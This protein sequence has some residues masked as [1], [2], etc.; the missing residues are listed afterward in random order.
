MKNCAPF[1]IRSPML[2]AA[3]TRL[4]SVFRGP[5]L[6]SIE[7]TSS[8][9]V[10]LGESL[11]AMV[12]TPPF[13]RRDQ[14]PTQGG[15]PQRSV[16]I[17]YGSFRGPLLSQDSGAATSSQSERDIPGKVVQQESTDTIGRKKASPQFTFSSAFAIWTSNYIG[18]WVFQRL[19]SDKSYFIAKEL[20]M[21]E[22]TFVQDLVILCQV[23][24][25][26]NFC[27]TCFGTFAKL[28]LTIL[29]V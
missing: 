18:I 19:P 20:L 10:T 22:R 9:A 24:E 15:T 4:R 2:L 23:S 11:E 1:E 25:I 6:Q 21:T 26:W 8:G 7:S 14:P 17:G 27:H 12:T 16:P 29:G 13:P 5:R 28:L 3:R